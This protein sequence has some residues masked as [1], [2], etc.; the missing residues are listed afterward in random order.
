MMVSEWQEEELIVHS[1]AGG[2]A[3]SS[4]GNRRGAYRLQVD[5]E[6]LISLRIAGVGA[7]RSHGG[8]GR[9]F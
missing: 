9:S 4:Q 8:R 3:F 7:Y 2:G 5:R 1:E 6:E